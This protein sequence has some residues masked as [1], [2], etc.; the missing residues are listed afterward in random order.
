MDLKIYRKESGYLPPKF[1]KSERADIAKRIDALSRVDRPGITELFLSGQFYK[2][3]AVESA[4]VNNPP[5]RRL[6]YGEAC[7]S[8]PESDLGKAGQSGDEAKTAQSIV[9]WVKKH[10]V[11][12][13]LCNEGE[14]S[15]VM[16]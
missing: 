11:Q 3:P 12:N 1:T 10:I 6:D 15:V 14:F 4:I 2:L 7:Y 16:D 9:L 5:L 8:I 13:G